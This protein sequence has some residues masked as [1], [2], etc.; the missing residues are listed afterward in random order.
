M[1]LCSGGDLA[2]YLTDTARVCACP[3]CICIAVC[4]W[5]TPVHLCLLYVFPAAVPR[6]G[7]GHYHPV[8]RGSGA[9]TLVW[10]HPQGHPRSQL[11][12][13]LHTAPP[14]AGAYQGE[15]VS[16]ARC[17]CSKRG[18]QTHMSAHKWGCMCV[19]M[20]VQISDFGLS[21]ALSNTRRLDLSFTSTTIG[22][23]GT[24]YCTAM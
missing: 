18:L 20:Y 9:P 15:K 8:W 5:R 4:V 14:C 11:P 16:F 23:Y 7:L 6:A 1:E 2:S 10:S 12:C 22:P 21:H 13:R 17:V 3:P 24:R 19:C